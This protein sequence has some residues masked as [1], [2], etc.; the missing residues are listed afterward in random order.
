VEVAVVWGL[1]LAKGVIEFEAAPAEDRKVATLAGLSLPAVARQS[2]EALLGRT[3]FDTTTGRESR[4]VSGRCGNP[5]LHAHAPPE[6]CVTT[7]R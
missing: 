4:L 3:M 1:F 7:T 2:T 6:R 5:L